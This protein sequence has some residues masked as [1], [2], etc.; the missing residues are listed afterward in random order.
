[1]IIF[2]AAGGNDSRDRQG[3]VAVAGTQLN[4]TAGREAELA[5]GGNAHEALL[6]IVAGSHPAALE[7]P[8]GIH[9]CHL[10][11][12]GARQN[13]GLRSGIRRHVKI[14]RRSH[15]P[16]KP[17]CGDAIQNRGV[18]ERGFAARRCR[19]SDHDIRAQRAEFLR[20]LPFG[21]QIHI[22]QCGTNRRTAGKRNQRNGQPAAARARATSIEFAGTSSG[23]PR[24]HS[25]RNTGAGSTREARPKRHETPQQRDHRREDQNDREAKSNEASGATPKIPMPSARANTSPSAYPRTPPTSASNNCSATKNAPTARRLAPS[26]FINPISERRSS[27]VVADVAPTASAAANKAAIVTIHISPL[28]RVRIRPSPS[29]TCRIARTSTPGNCC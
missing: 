2:G 3:N 17:Q 11:K 24:A 21:I 7:L 6:V 23:S 14:R 15:D 25:P 8:P 26:A 10:V 19:R 27:T 5:R 4:G 1:M 9:F 29:A 12:P 13:D 16:R 28:T 20:Q 18:G 22:Q